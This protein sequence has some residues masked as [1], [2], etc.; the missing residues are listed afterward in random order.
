M[1][2]KD[3]V[4]HLALRIG[5]TQVETRKLLAACIAELKQVLRIH[6]SRPGYVSCAYAR[7]PNGL[8]PPLQAENAAASQK[9]GN[10]QPRCYAQTPGKQAWRYG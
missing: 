3:I 2:T 10:L 9:S 4:R 5:K 7:P 1:N 8:Q 6:D